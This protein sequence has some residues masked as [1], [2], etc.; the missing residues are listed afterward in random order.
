M[1]AEV[2]DASSMQTH[3]LDMR[4]VSLAAETGAPEQAVWKVTETFRGLVTTVWIDLNGQVLREEGPMGFAAVRESAEDA[5]AKGWSSSQPFD[6]VAAVAVPLHG[7]IDDPRHARRLELRVTGPDGWMVP[8]DAR[9]RRVG[10]RVVVT[11]EPTTGG[12]F[13]LPYRDADR[14]SDLAATAFLQTDHPRI[15]Q[16]ARDAVAGE[17][18]AR[19]AVNRL[20]RWVFEH[21]RKVPTASIPNA[22]QAL[23]MGEGDCNEHAVLFAALA[24]ALGIPT[25]VVA[26]TVYV[27]G[28]LLYHAWNEVWL[29]DAWVS[30]DT[31]MDQMPVD[32]SHLKLLEGGPETHAGLLPLLG[33]LSV[34]VIASK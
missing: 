19:R 32:A 4:V 30:L 34:D 23:A 2:F 15:R 20:R 5:L 3:P 13:T 29:G 7:T 9:Q 25:R 31:T 33:K 10:D 24:R 17:S 12:S 26:G 11:R 14:R 28:A 1:R 18:D 16:A 8:E 21:V 6:L 27:D 22:L